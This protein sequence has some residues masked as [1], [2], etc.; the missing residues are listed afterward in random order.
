MDI[1]LLVFDETEYFYDYESPLFNY[2][3]ISRKQILESFKLNFH[4]LINPADSSENVIFKQHIK[5]KK[6]ITCLEEHYFDQLNFVT[7][8]FEMVADWFEDEKN[9]TKKEPPSSDQDKQK[10]KG[11]YHKKIKLGSSKSGSIL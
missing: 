7:D 10:C 9:E 1:E 11:L 4:G 2:P 6:S 3:Y 8:V 5:F